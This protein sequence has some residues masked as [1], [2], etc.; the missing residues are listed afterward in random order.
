MY[1]CGDCCSYSNQT[2]SSICLHIG[3]WLKGLRRRPHSGADTTGHIES[4]HGALKR[5]LKLDQRGTQG[6]HLDWMIVKLIES[7]ERHYEYRLELN[8][9]GF[10]KNKVIADIV[11]KSAIV[12]KEIKDDHCSHHCTH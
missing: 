6:Q 1:S 5:W 7:V 10:V 2:C 11:K 9:L 3:M 12:A 8:S 4:Y